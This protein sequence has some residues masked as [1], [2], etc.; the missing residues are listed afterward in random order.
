MKD[1]LQL[2]YVARWELNDQYKPKIDEKEKSNN[3][4]SLVQ[5]KVKENS[6]SKETLQYVLIPIPSQ[7]SINSFLKRKERFHQN[8]LQLVNKSHQKFLTLKHKQKIESQELPK[9]WDESFDLEKNTQNVPQK[10]LEEFLVQTENNSSSNKDLSNKKQTVSLF[11][12]EESN[13][14]DSQYN[15]INVEQVLDLNKD[16]QSLPTS[17]IK[18]VVH[19]EIQLEKQNK[20][21]PKD[22]QSR[23]YLLS[24]LPDLCKKLK[25]F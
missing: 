24:L 25:R 18:K 10:T 12:D 14:G 8:L 5:M 17:L 7:Y 6:A 1:F 19:R 22:K 2:L 13:S 9:N 4:Y 11:S 21:K 23:L 16:L 3:F 20:E 15:D